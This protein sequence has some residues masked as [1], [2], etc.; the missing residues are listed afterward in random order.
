VPLDPDIVLGERQ[1][2]AS[3]DLE[4]EHHQVESGHL[5]GHRVLDLEPGVH[6][7]EEDLVAVLVV[8]ELHGA[9]TGVADSAAE[10]KGR[11][12]RNVR[13]LAATLGGDFPMFP[14]D[15][16]DESDV[17]RLGREGRRRLGRVDI[18]VNGA[19]ASASAP[20]RKISL[21]EWNRMIAAN[22]TSVFL[23]TREF[24]PDMMERGFGRVANLASRAGLGGAK[25]IAHYSAAKHA[26]VGLTRCVA[27]E[28]AGTGVTVNAVCPGY[29]DTPMTE[30]TLAFV[31]AR[32]GLAREAAL[33]AVLETT[34]QDRLLTADEVAEEVLRLC[35]EDA[36]GVNGQAVLLPRE[37]SEP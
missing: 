11:L 4:L 14:C 3:G 21:E 23:C 26:V 19:G 34:G 12:E 22:A 10:P 17:K 33:A 9:N 31:E 28:V 36:G 15:V 13:D 5:F 7:D 35:R 32:T 25:Y 30:R 18:L 37:A 29:V 2:V 27:L 20:L 6:L 24:V 8:Q 1:L 16:T